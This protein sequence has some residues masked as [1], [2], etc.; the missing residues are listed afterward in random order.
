MAIR[1]LNNEGKLDTQTLRKNTQRQ[2]RSGRPRV[3]DV[4]DKKIQHARKRSQS[5]Q[6]DNVSPL[7]RAAVD[8][9]MDARIMRGQ[10]PM[11][12]QTIYRNEQ[13]NIGRDIKSTQRAMQKVDKG[14]YEYLNL[15]RRLSAL[16]NLSREMKKSGTYDGV[17][18]E[19]SLSTRISA[20][21]TYVNDYKGKQRLSEQRKQVQAIPMD[22]GQQRFYQ[23]VINKYGDLPQVLSPAL[24]DL[25]AE[26]DSAIRRYDSAQASEILTRMH[27]MT[28]DEYMQTRE[29]TNRRAAGLI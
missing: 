17:K 15:S 19:N 22:A 10:K 11:K 4:Q 9:I 5:I 13:R 28:G 6:L 27:R 14:S 2:A 24:T 25:M 18:R 20:F 7:Q 3:N 8:E 23:R 26:F 12:L 16:Q 29:Y 21:I 1:I